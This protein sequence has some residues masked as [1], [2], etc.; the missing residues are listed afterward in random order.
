LPLTFHPPPICLPAAA[1]AWGA[2]LA[3]ALMW[4]CEICCFIGERFVTSGTLFFLS[5]ELSL[6]N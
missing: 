5:F 2:A 6:F 1:N 4:L 3:Q